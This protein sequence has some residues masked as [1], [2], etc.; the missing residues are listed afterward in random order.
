MAIYGGPKFLLKTARQK[1]GIFSLAHP[2][3]QA[4]SRV[5]I[6]AGS[7]MS[8]LIHAIHSVFSRTCADSCRPNSR[9][10][11]RFRDSLST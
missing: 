3:G 9:F 4:A 8:P 5:G 10:E 11:H 7:Y 6:G 1:T 2:K